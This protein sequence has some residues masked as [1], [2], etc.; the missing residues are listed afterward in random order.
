MELIINKGCITLEIAKDLST[1]ILPSK[2]NCLMRHNFIMFSILTICS[3][4]FFFLLKI[5]IIR[6]MNT[7]YFHS[8]VV[9]I[10][11]FHATEC[12]LNPIQNTKYRLFYIGFNA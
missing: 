3:E 5:F 12:H 8:F 10:N 9:K 6:K 7:N 1:L 4:S 11:T 2:V